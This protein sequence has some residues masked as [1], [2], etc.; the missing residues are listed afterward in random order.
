MTEQLV[1][2]LSGPELFSLVELILNQ[3]VTQ[4]VKHY[5]CS[6]LDGN[7]AMVCPSP[8]RPSDTALK[9]LVSKARQEKQTKLPHTQSENK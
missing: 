8:P 1:L 5:T 7:W 9:V 6:L 4:M 3:T 2:S